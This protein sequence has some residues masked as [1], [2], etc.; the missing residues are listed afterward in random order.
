MFV[1]CPRCSQQ[2]YENATQCAY[3]G[4]PLAPPPQ[5]MP[6]GFAST[7][8]PGFAGGTTGGGPGTAGGGA[9]S[10]PQVGQ[11]IDKK[12]RVERILGEGGMGVVY[13]A[14]DVNADQ[15]VVIKSIRP[16][17]ANRGDFRERTL[18]EGKALAK[19]DHQ[20]V[21][22]FNSIINSPETNELYI[23]MQFIE[24]ES[25]DRTLEKANAAGQKLPIDEV[26]R[27]FKQILDGVGA[28]HKEGLMHRDLKPANV[29][30]RA[31]DGVAKVMDF[32]IAKAEGAT[33]GPTQAGGIVGSLFYMAPEQIKGQRDLDK[34]LDVYALGVVLYE[35]V[36]GHVPFDGETEYDIMTKH[37]SE[38]VPSVR[39]LRP[40]APPWVDELIQKAT[41]KDRNLRFQSCEDF[42]AALDQYAG[43]VVVPRSMTAYENSVVPD[44]GATGPRPGGTAV[45]G[46]MG[47]PPPGA[48][49]NP[50]G[51]SPSN[52]GYAQPVPS[53]PQKSGG[54][55]LIIGLV[56]V[57]LLGGGGAGAYFYFNQDSSTGKSS[58]KEEPKKD[59]EDKGKEKGKNKGKDSDADKDKDKDKVASKDKD[60]DKDKPKDKKKGPLDALVGKW[61]SDVTN[62]DLEAEKSG[63]DVE[64]KV[65]D[66]SQWKGAYT[67]GEVRFKLGAGSDDKTF[68]VTDRY[69]PYPLAPAKAYSP[70][71]LSS[72]TVEATKSPTGDLEAVLKDADTL[73]V[74]FATAKVDTKSA[75]ADPT[76]ITGCVPGTVNGVAKSTFRRQ[77]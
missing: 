74:T 58:A 51:A 59:D 37:M 16:E 77:K 20:N 42:R 36:T 1:S 14:M 10:Q 23:V 62:R 8:A 66:E 48:I 5:G 71:A 25:L 60:K 38:G 35:L 29:L 65:S 63:D 46:P 53:T 41:Q 40:D 47:T 24:G 22:R 67:K 28:A 56:V 54:S 72:C 11:L 3:C 34:R 49:S 18:A 76:T 13:V 26:A 33:K 7:N 43:G 64:F 31:K 30:V 32:G 15:K 73:E 75:P 52:P 61:K 50:Y 12:Y 45:M 44:G 69:R 21:V 9:A 57:L 55:G 39:H 27:L 70:D 4:A 17:F 19:I 6:A 2:N 68:K